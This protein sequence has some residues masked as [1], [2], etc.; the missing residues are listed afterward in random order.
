VVADELVFF[1]QNPV[2]NE[3]DS[4]DVQATTPETN[5]NIWFENAGMNR[6]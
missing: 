4:E 6:L 3:Q 2:Q 5:V 1:K